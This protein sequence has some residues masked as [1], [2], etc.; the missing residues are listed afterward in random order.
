[1]AGA[2]YAAQQ[3]SVFPT[4]FDTPELILIYAALI[5]GGAGSLG[6]AVAGAVILEVTYDGF[7]RS[8]NWSGA[9]FYL[10]ILITLLVK[11]RP[12]RRLA[13]VLIATV[14]LG[15]IAYAMANAIHPTWVAGGPQSGTAIKDL[16]SN[17]VIVPAGHGGTIPSGFGNVGFVILIALVITLVQVRGRWRTLLLPPTIYLAS[18]VWESRLVGQ[19]AVTRQILIGAILIVMMNARPQGL[20]GTRRVEVV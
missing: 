16:L 11:L 3:T 7:L 5:L 12:W 8:T 15:F 4:N 2:V 9:I 1:M 18:C 6:G 13:G 14:A 19:P 10:L 17:W 20:L